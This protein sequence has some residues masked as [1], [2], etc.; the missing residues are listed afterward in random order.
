MAKV[1]GRQLVS[2]TIRVMCVYSVQVFIQSTNT[3]C[4]ILYNKLWVVLYWLM[5]LQHLCILSERNKSSPMLL[6]EFS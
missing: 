4:S 3:S 5:F 2:E 1:L 6:T